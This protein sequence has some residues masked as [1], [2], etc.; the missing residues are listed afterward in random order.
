[1][2]YNVRESEGYKSRKVIIHLETQ[3]QHDLLRALFYF[4][5]CKNE[6]QFPT[7]EVLAAKLEND[8]KIWLYSEDG[9]NFKE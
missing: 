3:E 8:L 5:S 9:S 1:M 6:S 2:K 7:A 4:L